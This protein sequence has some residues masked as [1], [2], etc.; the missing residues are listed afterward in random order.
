MALD[1]YSA[2]QTAILLWLARPGDPLLQPSVP[3]MI[4]LFEAE[5]A[6]RLQTIGAEQQEILYPYG[7]SVEL[8][9]DFARLRSAVTEDGVPLAQVPPQGPWPYANGGQARYFS[10][11]G[12][13]DGVCVSGGGAVMQFAPNSVST[14]IVITYRRGLPP[15][16]DA[17]PSNWLLAEHPDCY[18]FGSLVEAE[19]FIGADE[20]ALAWGQRREMSFGSIE[21]ADHRKR[22]AGAPLQMRTGVPSP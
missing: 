2:L 7:A 22:W 21:Q 12:G 9:A 8:P 13:G 18:L 14:P 4:R 6:R 15:L 17:A 3:D 16:S 20:R 11:V 1:S 19:A 10:I 5:A